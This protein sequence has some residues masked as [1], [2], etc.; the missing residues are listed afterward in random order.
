MSSSLSAA[1]DSA[2][3]KPGLLRILGVGFGIAVIFGGTVGVGILR[4]PGAV[5]AQLGNYWLIL[6]AWMV[7]GLYALLGSISI[8][9][10]GAMLPRRADSTSMPVGHLAGLRDSRPGGETGSTIVLCSPMLRLRSRNIL[11]SFGLMTCSTI[12]R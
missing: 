5:A 3:R 7:G 4:L 11:A 9:E 1:S 10:L 2:G 6:L 12:I 8:T